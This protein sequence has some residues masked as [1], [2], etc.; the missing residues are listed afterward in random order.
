MQVCTLH[1]HSHPLTVCSTSCDP[2]FQLETTDCV[3]ELTDGCEAAGQPCQDGRTCVS[4]LSS[5][6]YYSCQCAEGYTGQNCTGKCVCVCIYVYINALLL[7][8]TN[9]ASSFL[10]QIKIILFPIACFG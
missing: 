3:C 5:P 9:K 10:T 8:I 2:G 7:Q 6:P 1:A 4:D